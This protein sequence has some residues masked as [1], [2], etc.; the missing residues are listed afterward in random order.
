MQLNIPGVREYFALSID[1]VDASVFSWDVLFFKTEREHLKHHCE[2]WMR[3]ITS[4]ESDPEL[5]ELDNEE[6]PI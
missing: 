6:F 3:A 2:R 1:E 4:H 5:M